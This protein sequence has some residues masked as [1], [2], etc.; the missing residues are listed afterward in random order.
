MRIQRRIINGFSGPVI[1]G[2]ETIPPPEKEQ[3]ALHAERAYWFTGQIETRNRMGSVMMAD[4]TAFT[5]GRDQHI[6]VY[7]RELASEDFNAADDQG[8]AWA[9]L[10][11]IEKAHGPVAPL[12]EK[13]KENGWYVAKN[14]TLR[15]LH[16]SK[17]KI[18]NRDVHHKPGDL[19]HGAII[20]DVFTPKGGKVQKSGS[21]EWEQAKAWA[22]ILH[23]LT[24]DE[25]TWD[26]QH[27]FGLKHLVNRVQTRKLRISNRRRRVTLQQ[28]VY[29]D[30]PIETL[31]SSDLTEAEDLALCVFHSY[32]VNAPSIAYRLLREALTLFEPKEDPFCFG[33]FLLE[34]IRGESYGNWKKR[35]V[36]TR[37]EAMRVD[38]WDARLFEGPAP[39]MPR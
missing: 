20:R 11:A 15:W 26:V 1:Y 16:H 25:K 29:K 31:K 37:Q 23:N 18:K 35:W 33:K 24:A 10:A 6:A 4:G 9:L 5:I 14:G 27:D 36:R 28:A 2:T 21:R 32:T 8:G 38:W 30:R 19:V 22:E 7:P 13:L 17:T 3:A 12:W 39:V 34:K